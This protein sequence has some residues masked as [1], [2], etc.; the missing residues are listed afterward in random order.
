MNVRMLEGVAHVPPDASAWMSGALTM[1]PAPAWLREQTSGAWCGADERDAQSYRLTIRAGDAGCLIAECLAPT[2]TGLRHARATLVQILRQFPSQAPCCEIDDR[3]AI[4]RR[5]VMLDVSRCR[6]PTMTEFHR[7]IGQLSALKCNHVQFYTEHTFAYEGAESVWGGWDPLTPEQVREI[8]V[9]CAA[10]GID[11]AANQN[12]FGHLREW[13]EKPAFAHLAETHGDWMFDVWPRSGPFSLCPTDP[14]SLRFVE[15]LLGELLPHFSG[16]LVNIGC[17]ETYDIAYGRSADVVR[18][19]GRGAV[20]AE[21]VGQIA[22]VARGLGK[23]SM[24][25]ADI[26]LSHPD[27]LSMLEADMTPLAWGY[28]PDAPWDDWCGALT[29]HGP[30]WMHGFWL[31]PGTSS[32]RSITGRTSERRGNIE[33]AARAALSQRAAGLLVCDWGDSGHWQTWPVALRGI[34]DGLHAAWCGCDTPDAG[35]VSLHA[36]DDPS[37][38]IGAWL[39]VLGDVDEPLRSV[40]MPLS[41]PGQTGRIRNQTAIFADLFKGCDEARE[42]GSREVYD[43]CVARLEALG[44]APA[45]SC[46]L[47]MDELRHTLAMTRLAMDRFGR[48]RG[49]STGSPP[50]SWHEI[51][52]EHRRLWVERSRSGGLAQSC[53]FFRKI[54]PEPGEATA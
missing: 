24:F 37:L 20:F 18:R 35:T 33:G 29:R 4:G 51:E 19:R 6:V 38:E 36:F 40:A 16:A 32:W 2:S 53:A 44:N 25:W 46:P 49:W 7:I 41:R 13:L 11:M 15:R 45:A 30:A 31:C 14:A 3:P 17:D 8:D 48:R 21:F 1:S 47:L 27:C 12:C 28:E 52:A 42:V 34:A 10:H 43:G 23:R 9:A 39:D 22:A 26:A 5:G 50:G 54:G